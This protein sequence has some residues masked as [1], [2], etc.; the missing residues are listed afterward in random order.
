[1]ILRQWPDPRFSCSGISVT[2]IAIH[3]NQGE[4]KED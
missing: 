4:E 3:I 1:M 2:I